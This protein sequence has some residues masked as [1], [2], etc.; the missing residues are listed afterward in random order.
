MNQMK[1][2]YAFWKEDSRQKQYAWLTPAQVVDL[3]RAGFYVQE[4]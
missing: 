3:R 1:K 4:T 2:L